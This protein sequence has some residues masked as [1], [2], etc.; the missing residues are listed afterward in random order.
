MNTLTREQCIEQR[1]QIVEATVQRA[2]RLPR[3]RDKIKAKLGDAF[4]PGLTRKVIGECFDQAVGD[5]GA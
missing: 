5:A 1:E 4:A 3:W 2:K